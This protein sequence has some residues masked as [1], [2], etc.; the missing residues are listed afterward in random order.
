M[1]LCVIIYGIDCMTRKHPDCC[2]MLI[3]DFNQLNDNF[4]KTLQV[5]LS[6]QRV[7]TGS[8]TIGQ[9]MDEYVTRVRCTSY[10]I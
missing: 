2:V 4:I 1:I 6:S 3:G 10:F 9:D 8:F 5:R 7:H